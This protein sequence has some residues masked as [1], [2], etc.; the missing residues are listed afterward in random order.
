MRKTLLLLSVLI[1]A[2]ASAQVYKR[3]GPDGKIY[4]SDTPEPGATQVEVKPAQTISMPPVSA[5]ADSAPPPAADEAPA[6]TELSILSPEEG[7]GVR[8]NDGNV[9]VRLSLQPGLQ[10][11]HSIVLK[12][13]GEDGESIQAGSATE[14]RLRNM[15]RGLHSVEAQVIDGSGKALISSGTITFHVLRVGG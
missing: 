15:S 8:A 1:C 9:A 10:S 7:Q 3:V 13:D 14:V 12:V 2:S 6:Y 4:F 11:G 5:P